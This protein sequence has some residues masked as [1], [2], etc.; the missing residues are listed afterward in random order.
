MGERTKV[1]FGRAVSPRKP[2]LLIDEPTN[3]LDAAG[4]RLL[5]NYLAG[6]EGFILVSHDRSFLDR[7]T[8]H[9]LAINRSD[10]QVQRGNFSSWWENKRQQDQLGLEQNQRL[11]G[12]SPVGSVGYRQKANWSDQVEKTKNRCSG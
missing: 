12:N 8:D 5:G 2:F 10:I 9:I 11:K 4:K 7:C 3:H 1:A 6:K